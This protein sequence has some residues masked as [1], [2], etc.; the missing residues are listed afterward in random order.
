[1][2]YDDKSWNYAAFVKVIFCR[3][4]TQWPCSLRPLDFNFILFHFPEIRYMV[5]NQYGYRN[6]QKSTYILLLNHIVVNITN[7]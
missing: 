3:S 5:I 6:S 4:Q 7:C 1:M 2:M